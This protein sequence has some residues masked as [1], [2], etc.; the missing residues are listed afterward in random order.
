MNQWRLYPG[1]QSAMYILNGKPKADIIKTYLFIVAASLFKFGVELKQPDDQY[2]RHIKIILV[3][4]ISHLSPSSKSSLSPL[5]YIFTVIG[6][7]D[8]RYRAQ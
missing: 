5:C 4:I 8:I 6:E 2:L 1:N 3:K 7:G